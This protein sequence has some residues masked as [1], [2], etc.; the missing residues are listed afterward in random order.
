MSYAATI[1][2]DAPDHWWRAASEGFL[3]D[4]GQTLVPWRAMAS[5]PE[6]ATLGF[7]GP[8]AGMFS[9]LHQ[10]GKKYGSPDPTLPAVPISV[11]LWTWPFAGG[12][13]GTQCCFGWN[14]DTTGVNVGFT[15]TPF[16]ARAGTNGLVLTGATT[17][18]IQNWY[19]LVWTYSAGNVGFLYV[20]GVQDATGTGSGWAPSAA[21]MFIGNNSAPN[22]AYYGFISEV[23]TYGYVLSAAKALAHYNAAL[24]LTSPPVPTAQP[25]VGLFTSNPGSTGLLDRVIAD[26]ERSY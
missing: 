14:G 11:E 3:P 10:N 2:A 19:H 25:G 12:A 9:W 5:D 16:R 1:A 21:G 15:G 6:I 24:P 26:V 18:A 20:N 13:M 7:S 17:R 4:Q 8:G 23:A 22:N